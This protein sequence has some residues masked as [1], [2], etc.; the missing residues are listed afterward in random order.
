[1]LLFDGLGSFN[2]SL[3]LVLQAL[4]EQPENRLFFDAFCG[5]LEETAD[6]L[7]RDALDG[8][9]PAG[10]P[11]QRWWDAPLGARPNS[12]VTGLRVLAHQTCHLQ[13]ARR[14][15]DGA[16]AALGHSVGLPAAIV[17]GLGPRRLD[18]FLAVVRG[19]VRLLVTALVRGH[20]AVRYGGV[21]SAAVDRRPARDEGTR[22]GPM[23]SLTGMSRPELRAVVDDH[24]DRN[25]HSLTLGLFNTPT[26]HVLSGCPAEL[27][28]FHSAHTS[29]LAGA[30]A[31][32]AFLPHTIPFHSPRLEPALART[33][34][35]LEFVG[36]LP[37]PDQ[38]RFPVYAADSGRNL[39]DSTD[40]TEEVLAQ[41]LVRPIEWE[42]AVRH[43][44]DDARIE[45][46]LDFGPGPGA[47]RFA[48]ECL[49]DR[50][51][52]LRFESAHHP[53]PRVR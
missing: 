4:R 43:A 17:A 20:E 22:P 1:M 8:V 41:V 40:L 29:V 35:D 44:V 46:I 24:N 3:P 51:R 10:L 16:V 37:P 52:G 28:D 45:R 23:A 9:L 32:W 26:A 38:L 19:C 6:H 5:A 47:R 31:S 7:G 27:L 11:V 53:F 15:P 13:P 21:G 48:R 39:Q 30:G 34:T 18:E 12:V 50:A 33:R 36:Q 42:I 25:G 49:R 14:G 2:S